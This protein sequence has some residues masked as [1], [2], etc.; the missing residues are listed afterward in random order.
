MKKKAMV[1]LAFSL[2]IITT[3]FLSACSKIKPGGSITFSAEKIGTTPVKEARSFTYK[4]Y[5]FIYYNVYNDGA[6]NFVMADNS[7]YIANKDIQFGLKVKTQFVYKDTDDGNK[8]LLS[9]NFLDD[10]GYYSYSI[11]ETGF[12]ICGVGIE[13]SM[14][15]TDINIGK[16]T[17]WC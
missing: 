1:D 12:V 14:L 5:E 16:I 10:D 9:Y 7:S 2:A 13:Y 3:A 6:G 8:E 4:G 11:V 15:Y 17:H